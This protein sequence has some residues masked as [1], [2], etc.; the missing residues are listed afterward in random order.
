MTADFDVGVSVGP[1]NFNKTN[2]TNGASGQSTNPTLT[3]ETSSGATSYE[4]CLD[5]TNNNI[6]DGSWMNNGNNTSFGLSGLSN[7][8]T[9]YWQVKALNGSGSTSANGG[10]WWSFTTV[11]VTDSYEPND[12]YSQ[13]KW[14][15]NG[16]PLSLSIHTTGD[17]DWFKFIVRAT[18]EVV[19]ETSGPADYD[20]LLGLYDSSFTPVEINDNGG[21]GLYSSIDRICGVDSLEPGTYYVKIIENGNDGPIPSYQLNLTSTPCQT[22]YPI[23]LPSITQADSNPNPTP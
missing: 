20:T 15:F 10:T 3:W 14:M 7:G 11:I 18:S 4:Y 12:I 6:C 16:S 13:S 8:T 9:Y 22:Q 21:L 2:P 19:I 23:F 1:G 5:T 17:R